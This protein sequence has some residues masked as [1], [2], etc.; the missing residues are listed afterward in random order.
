MNKIDANPI[1][2]CGGDGSP[3]NAARIKELLF[4][5][6]PQT[7]RT[8]EQPRNPNETPGA[9]GVNPDPSHGI[10]T[11]S[12]VFAEEYRRKWGK[13]HLGMAIRSGT[14]PDTGRI[15]SGRPMEHDKLCS[16]HSTHP[17]VSDIEKPVLASFGRYSDAIFGR[18]NKW[19][20]N[21]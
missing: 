13:C 7:G 10:S 14:V 8:P 9:Q 5:I 12:R 2:R 16:D 11:A 20:S 19:S 3:P 15:E 21:P 17:D 6:K 18:F 4:P 1:S